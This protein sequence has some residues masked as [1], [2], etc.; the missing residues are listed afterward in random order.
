MI[1]DRGRL[2]PDSPPPCLQSPSLTAWKVV[3]CSAGFR[4]VA[5]R[6]SLREV[7]AC[8]WTSGAEIDHTELLCVTGQGPAPLYA[9]VSSAE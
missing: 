7:H 2:M 6:L 9:S 3:S 1:Q 8:S 5:T 4:S